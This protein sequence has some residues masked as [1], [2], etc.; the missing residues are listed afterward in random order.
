MVR[1]YLEE[2]FTEW[3]ARTWLGDCAEGSFKERIAHYQPR[4]PQ[5]GHEKQIP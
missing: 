4:Q 1:V 3:I 2:Q 5:R